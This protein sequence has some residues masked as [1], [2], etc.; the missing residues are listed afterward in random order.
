M[1]N[2]SKTFSRF[3]LIPMML[4]IIGIIVT[5]KYVIDTDPSLT[6]IQFNHSQNVFSQYS[7]N[8][9]EK[10]KPIKA[11][12][13][14]QENYLGIIYVRF[15]VDK[16]SAQ[17]LLFTL[18]EKGSKQ[19][20]FAQKYNS[21]Q[22]YY[23]PL[24]PFGFPIITDSKDKEYEIEIRLLSDA[25]A[26]HPILIS[27]VEPVV[28]SSYKFPQEILAKDYKLLSQVAYRK[29]ISIIQSTHHQKVSL[30]FFS[31]FIAYMIVSLFFGKLLKPVIE[32]YF[33][34]DIE[35][36]NEP[37][38]R[39]F[40]L[41][42][43]LYSFLITG[44][45]EQTLALFFILLLITDA[46]RHITHRQLFMLGCVYLI[47]SPIQL[48]AELDVMSKKMTVISYFFFVFGTIHLMISH[49]KQKINNFVYIP[50]FKYIFKAFILLKII[51]NIIVEIGFS[52]TKQGVKMAISFGYTVSNPIIFWLDKIIEILPGKIESYKRNLILYTVRLILM[53]IIL[54]FVSI[55]FIVVVKF[56]DKKIERTKINPQIHKVEPQIVY[57]ANKIIINGH[58]LGWKENNGIRLMN[59]Y[60]EVQTELWTDSKII[61]TVPL[62]WKDAEIQLWVEKDVQWS[63]SI[64]TTQ[65]KRQIIQ[66]LQIDSVINEDHDKYLEQLKDLDDETLIINGYNPKEIK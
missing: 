35:Y 63:G 17:D 11:S 43:G 45:H 5:A 42:L 65:S 51:V 1:N 61:F 60:G 47:L 32:T 31:P 24:Y 23:L 13:K 34:K 59:Q 25:I 46:A 57:P 7:E 8:P 55:T 64:I 20:L 3:V 38:I 27:D 19:A 40:L 14:A 54:V 30:F 15:I 29:I 62:S 48:L 28:I 26:N 18:R 49:N 37:I 16:E 12:F 33:K 44:I 41:L 66:L 52:F 22:F 58:N 56:I 39:G 50:F 2:F 9:L 6:S 21:G 10:N 53:S 4:F 36:F